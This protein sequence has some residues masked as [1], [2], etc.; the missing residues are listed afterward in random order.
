MFSSRALKFAALLLLVI[1][2]G[3]VTRACRRERDRA[4]QSQRLKPLE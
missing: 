2:T 1:V 4:D 3:L